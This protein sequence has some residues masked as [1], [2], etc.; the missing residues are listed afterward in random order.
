MVTRSSMARL[1]GDENDLLAESPVFMKAAG[2]TT[3]FSAQDRNNFS[4]VGK[5]AA[6]SVVN[7]GQK[8]ESAGANSKGLTPAEDH[9]SDSVQNQGTD[10]EIDDTLVNDIE[11]YL[12]SVMEGNEPVIEM[13]DSVIKSAGAKCVAAALTFCESLTE[14]RLSNCQIG[15]EGASAIFQEA[16][17]CK[18][19]VEVDLSKNQ[20]TEKSFEAIDK[21]LQANSVIKKVILT[22]IAVKKSSFAWKRLSKYGEK[23]VH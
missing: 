5:S 21:M 19:L 11:E 23:I 6:N 10:G 9:P 13:S 20:V 8:E 22:E 12:K 4:E 3:P 15:D 2:A 7:K 1:A 16:S 17:Q 18:S 14:L